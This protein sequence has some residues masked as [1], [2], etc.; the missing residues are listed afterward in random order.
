MEGIPYGRPAIDDL[1]V[2]AVTEALRS[3]WLTSGPR[4]ASFERAFAK[5]V[6]SSE[7]V[8]VAN[9]TAALKT[10]LDAA[11]V[12][13]GDEV[14]LPS[15]TFVA[16]ANAVLEQGA[17]P[18]FADVEPGTLVLDP[19][20]VEARSSPRTKAILAVDYAGHPCDYDALRKIARGRGAVLVG[21]ACHALGA[22]YRGRP[23]G[24]VADLTVFSFHPVKAITTGEGGMVT[25]DDAARAERMRRF[26]HHGLGPAADAAR[27]WYRVMTQ[28]GSNFRL[29]DFQC[30]LGERQLGNLAAWTRRRREIAKRYRRAFAAQP[31]VRPLAEADDVAH[32]YHLFVVRV[33]APVRDALVLSLRSAGIEAMVHYVPVHLHPYHR[34]RLGTGPGD[35]PQTEA[36]FDEILSLPIYPHLSDAGVDRVVDAVARGLGGPR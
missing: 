20:S 35:L 16:T 30:A 4:V 33:P 8:A 10:A 15:L 27:P 24:S 25:T 23:V 14:V 19:A 5:S 7:A 28:P 2:A 17:R 12:G 13:P 3:G 36:A 22:T 31:A 26:R 1:D 21:D 18:V 29:T 9:G 6:G 11:G 34:E 32:A